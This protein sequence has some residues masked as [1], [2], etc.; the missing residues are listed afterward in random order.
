MTKNIKF[1][2]IIGVILSLALVL[3]CLSGCG[4]TTTEQTESDYY[5]FIATESGNDSTEATGE[6]PTG[7]GG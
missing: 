2:Q 3:G 1:K 7:V 4:N 5:E 6:P